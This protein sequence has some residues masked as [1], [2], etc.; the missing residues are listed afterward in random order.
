PIRANTKLQIVT[1]KSDAGL[2]VLRHSTAHLM[3][4][5]VTRLYPG[6]QVTIGPATDE[7][8]F[9]DFQ[10]DGG[11]TPDDLEKIEAEMRR[12]AAQDLPM[13][14]EEVSRSAA[15]KLFRDM[16]ETFKLEILAAIPEGDTISLYR[17]GEF[18]DL[19]RGPHVPS[20]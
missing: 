8:F 5:A 3:A 4:S 13:T 19:C 7:G 17:H 11:F 16:G 9:Y 14:R 12:I 10:R 18:V 6:T 1:V 20:T 15:E 2:E